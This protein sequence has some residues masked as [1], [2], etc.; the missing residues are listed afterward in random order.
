VIRASLTVTKVEAHSWAASTWASYGERIRRVQ[1]IA[2][3]L[4][5][6]LLPANRDNMRLL[7]GHMLERGATWQAMRAV[8]SAVIAWHTEHCLANPF[9][10]TQLD[11]FF[12]GLARVASRQTKQKEGLAPELV[13]ELLRQLSLRGRPIDLRDAAWIV[14]GFFGLRRMSEILVNESDTMGFRRQDILFEEDGVVS[15]WI[16]RAKNDPYGEGSRVKISDDTASGVR[17][18]S[19][20]L[21]YAQLLPQGQAP[22]TAFIQSTRGAQGWSGLPYRHLRQRLKELLGELL[23]FDASRLAKYSSHSLRRGGCDYAD[24][25]G[26]PFRSLQ[27]LG[28]W[29]SGKSMRLYCRGSSVRQS[30]RVSKFW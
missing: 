3:Q 18:V 19:I 7:F 28:C 5:I 22:G 2:G 8:R 11:R 9:I 21:R 27:E 1:R 25:R 4:G 24:R 10:D 29:K 15:L 6:Q 30:Q 26:A 12:M 16:R 23:G 20:L 17:P 14:L 13:F